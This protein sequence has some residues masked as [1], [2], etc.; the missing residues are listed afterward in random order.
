MRK[1]TPSYMFT[2]DP[3]SA[4]D[5]LQIEELKRRIKLINQVSAKNQRKRVS[6]KPRLG[7]NSQFAHLY[8]NRYGPLTIKME[9]GAR[10]D[11]Y[12]HDRR[13]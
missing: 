8:A 4:A 2:A 9:H 6:V 12:V 13:D 5:M 7:K 3:M 1:R 10:F 11:V